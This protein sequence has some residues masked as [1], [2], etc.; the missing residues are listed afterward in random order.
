LDLY[1]SHPRREKTI[2]RHPWWRCQTVWTADG[3][4]R[5][6]KSRNVEHRWLPPAAG[7]RWLQDCNP[8][9][10]D[11]DA[12]F[13]GSVGSVH[14][15]RQALIDWA[16]SRWG[17]RFAHFGP[18]GTRVTGHDLCGLYSST[19]TI[20][21]SAPAGYYWSDRVP[22]TLIRGGL[23]THP[24]TPGLDEAFEDA[25]VTYPRGDHDALAKKLDA[26]TPEAIAE[27]R[28][29]GKAVVASRNMC[30]HRLTQIAEEVL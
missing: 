6:W 4:N 12:C 21:D 14:E 25:F 9:T 26:L 10:F 15:G 7:H 22:L 18:N 19:I 27:M 17:R 5:P 8:D 13:T 30:T 28:A 24:V 20:G 2:G 11:L 3:G 29:H 1:W 23:L 16:R